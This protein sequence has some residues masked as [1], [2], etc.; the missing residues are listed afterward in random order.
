[1]LALMS[2][3][4]GGMVKPR[5]ST[6]WSDNAGATTEACRGTLI[7]QVPMCQLLAAHRTQAHHVR[8]QVR[9]RGKRLPAG[10]IV[11]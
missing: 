8:R 5:H 1:V 10:Q 11:V 9:V 7:V 4:H 6:S 3:T 2:M